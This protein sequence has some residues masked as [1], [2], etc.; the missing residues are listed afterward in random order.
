MATRF[1]KASGVGLFVLITTCV[2]TLS[3]HAQ[4]AQDHYNKA[5]ELL[6]QNLYEHSQPTYDQ[7]MA[8]V[9]KAIE[10]DPTVAEFYT[11]RGNLYRNKSDIGNAIADYSKSIQ[12]NPNNGEV[13]YWRAICYYAVKD[14]GKAWEDVHKAQSLGYTAF[15]GFIYDLQVATGQK[16]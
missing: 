3:A 11:F 12:I 7:A 9:T 6:N 15:G 1:R 13:Y 4:S 2:F 16:G 10:M 8:E 14:Y 5:K